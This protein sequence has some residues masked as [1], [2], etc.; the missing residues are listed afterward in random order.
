MTPKSSTE[1]ELRQAKEKAEEASRQKTE[2][3]ARVTHDLRTPLTGIIGFAE[4][5]YND[6][7]GPVPLSHKEYLGDILTSAR[8]LLVLINDVLDLTKVE[9]GKMEFNPETIDL[10]KMLD[11]T[12]TI[13]QAFI[14]K[15]N[16]HF[17]IKIDPSLKKIVI[18]PGRLK[19]VIYNYVSNAMKFAPENGHIS[20]RLLAEKNNR[21]RLEVE[22]NGPGI[23]K[24]DFSRLFREFEQID[25]KVAKLYPSSGLGLALAKR[26]VEAQGGE[27]GVTSTVG[28][29]SV[30][31]AVLPIKQE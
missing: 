15:K 12:R 6:K 9:S 28:K 2:F 4:L 23:R 17:E 27:V 1:E 10:E 26:I 21:F 5:M 19:Q 24:E 30:F 14:E 20:V 16:I 31:Y 22:D 13:F 3:L 29:G 25:K 8:H 7:V 18:D 11:D